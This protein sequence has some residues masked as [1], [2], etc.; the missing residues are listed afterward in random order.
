MQPLFSPHDYDLLETIVKSSPRVQ[1]A[2]LERYRIEDVEKELVYDTR[3]V[4]VVDVED[5][6]LALDKEKGHPRRLIQIF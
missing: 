6:L 5:K 4:H 3:S 1:Q 2:V